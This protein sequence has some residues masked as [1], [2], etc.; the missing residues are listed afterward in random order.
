MPAATTVCSACGFEKPKKEFERNRV[1]CQACRITANQKRISASYESYL[2]NLYSKSKNSN[3]RDPR[4]SNRD[5]NITYED[6]VA[7]W[8][9]QEG[10]CA[11]SGVY[12]THHIDGTGVKDNNASIDRISQE[13]GYTASNTQLVCY[14]VNIMK[15][16][17][18]E[19][20]F[21]WW[22]KTIANFTC[23]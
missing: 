5:W 12:L 19:D 23:D 7:K 16:N 6:L 1:Q 11:L 3:K 18:P 14:R 4:A 17:L 8:K 10:R 15:H 9:E 13:V 20:M 21:F 22:V 2:R